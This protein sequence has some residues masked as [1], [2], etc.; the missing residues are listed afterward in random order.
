[1]S[2]LQL[3]LLILAGLY[4]WECLCWLPRG[5]VALVSWFGNDWRLAQPGALAGNQRGGFVLA[6]P[7]PPLGWVLASM[8]FPVSLSPEGLLLYVSTNVNPG[9]RPAQTGRFIPFDEISKAVADGRKIKVNG[10]LLFKAPHPFT[11]R[12]WAAALTHIAKR[13]KADRAEAVE[14]FQ[15]DSFDD[16]AAEKLWQDFKKR[17]RTLR[18]L[19]N[20][21]LIYMFA[22]MPAVIWFVGLRL[23]WIELMAALLAQT[24]AIA[25]IFSRASHPVFRRRRTDA[26]PTPSCWRFRRPRPR[27]RTTRFRSRYCKLSIHWCPPASYCRRRSSRPLPRRYCATRDTPPCRCFPA[28]MPRRRRLNFTGGPGSARRWNFF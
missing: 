6:S 5:S 21:L 25:V 18:L 8:Q 12:I 13:P 3:L 15:R 24:I 7:L 20:G 9:W 23:T 22:V 17:S 16:Q 1:M 26:S 10:E 19:D 4:G 11:A 27:G 28:M 14:E 2:E